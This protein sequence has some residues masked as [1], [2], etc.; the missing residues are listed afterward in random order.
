[1][2]LAPMPP[3][4]WGHASVSQPFSASL[5]RIFCPMLCTPGLLRSASSSYQSPPAQFRGSSRFKK[6]RT[7]DW[8]ASS[9]ALN[10]RST[11]YRLSRR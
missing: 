2:W 3:Y 9:S 1:M 11:L 4:S 5:R 10:C 7:S 6:A 8:K